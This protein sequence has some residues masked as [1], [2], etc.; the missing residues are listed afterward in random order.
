ME[1]TKKKYS[2]QTVLDKIE[3]L[4]GED[5]FVL[6]ILKDQKISAIDLKEKNEEKI[7][8]KNTKISELKEL[9]NKLHDEADKINNIFKMYK[10]ADFKTLVD[11]LGLNIHFDEDAKIVEEK[12]PKIVEEKEDINL[13]KIKDLDLLNMTPIEAMNFLYELKENLK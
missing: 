3:N 10:T 5:S 9:V 7:K 8:N 13:K 4:M 2:S 12:L 11:V 6:A 1:S